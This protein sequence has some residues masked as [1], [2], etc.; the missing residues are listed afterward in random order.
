MDNGR[1]FFFT[2]TY[3][4]SVSMRGNYHDDTYTFS[5]PLSLYEKQMVINASLS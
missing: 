5:L 1:F 3:P 2:K 4:S